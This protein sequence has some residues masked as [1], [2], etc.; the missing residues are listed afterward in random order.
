MVRMRFDGDLLQK[1]VCRLMRLAREKNVVW[2]PHLPLHVPLTVKEV[3]LLEGAA[4]VSVPGIVQARRFADIGIRSVFVSLPPT[5][6]EIPFLEKFSNSAPLLLTVDH[7]VQAELLARHLSGREDEV[8]VVILLRGNGPGPGVRPGLDAVQLAQGVSRLKGLRVVGI[9]ASIVTKGKSVAVMKST[10]HTQRQF[11]RAGIECDL[12]SVDG[13]WDAIPGDN[14]FVTEFRDQ[15]LFQ[16]SD[17]GE[18]V[19]WWEAEVISRPALKS[20]VINAGLPLMKTFAPVWLPDFPDVEI[21]HWYHDCCVISTT[22]DAQ[23]LRIGDVVRIA[24]GN[25]FA[26][27]V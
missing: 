8:L 15:T 6:S 4:G 2:R 22:G 3:C 11:R 9:S 18:P 13:S 21:S 14:T 12:I 23:R 1:N 25:V 16:S 5:I 10:A 27:T 20:A 24:S 26:D 17:H 7:F 19:I